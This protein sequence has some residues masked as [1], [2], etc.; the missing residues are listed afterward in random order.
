[1]PN[2]ARIH[3]IGL[4][5]LKEPPPHLIDLGSCRVDMIS[6]RLSERIS[7]VGLP[8]SSTMAAT[9]SPRAVFLVVKS[10]TFMFK[11]LAK[12]V[13]DREGFP[14]SSKATFFGGP[15]CSTVLSFCFSVLS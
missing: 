4:K 11:D 15:R 12:P 3:C 13:N 5:D 9:Y 7:F 14:C 6:G 1:M 2:S 8:F 10:L